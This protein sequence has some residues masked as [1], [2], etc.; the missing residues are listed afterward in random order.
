MAVAAALRMVHTF[1]PVPKFIRRAEKAEL[2][3]RLMQ[4][5]ERLSVRCGSGLL[6]A[7][8]TPLRSGSRAQGL[9]PC[10]ASRARA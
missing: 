3:R 10:P 2:S 8:R 4:Y 1:D 9:Q 7:A 5:G 6:A